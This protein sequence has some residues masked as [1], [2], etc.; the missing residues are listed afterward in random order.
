MLFGSLL[1]IIPR[2][3]SSVI[4]QCSQSCAAYDCSANSGLRHDCHL[5]KP[6][7]LAIERAQK[8]YAQRRC[9]T[10]FSSKA[11][12]FSKY[13]MHLPN[14]SLFRQAINTLWSQHKYHTAHSTSHLCS[15]EALI[16][17]T[18]AASL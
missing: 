7:K 8:H 3:S 5:V 15:I 13:V 16:I 1:C 6:V 14:L 17:I 18:K 4:F 2:V 9:S 10:F 12:N 11:P